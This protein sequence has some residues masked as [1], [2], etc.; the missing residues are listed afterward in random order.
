MEKWKKFENK[1]VQVV[2][3]LNKN[4]KVYGNIYIKGKFSKSSR[5]V[6]V[7]LVDPG[8]Y[9]FMV[10]E[11]KDNAR[12]I[13]TPAIEAFVT[14]LKDLGAEKG[15]V[16]SNSPYT[17]GAQNLAKEFNIDLLHLVDDSDKDIRTIIYAT[18]LIS[19]VM[20]RGFSVG[21]GTT[22]TQGITFQDDVKKLTFIGV[23][24]NNVTAYQIFSTLW[25]ETEELAKSPGSYKYTLPDDRSISILGNDGGS[26]A[27]QKL[28]FNYEVIE[29]YFVGSVKMIDTSGIYNVKEKSYRTKSLKTEI[30][31][32]YE[33]EKTWR[34]I[35]N[36]KDIMK[37]VTFG[38]SMVSMYPEK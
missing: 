4:S 1:T 9:D 7:K 20:P 25:N 36:P 33:V 26:V 6:D 31:T 15:A 28:H 35:K 29:R 19:D 13:D 5:Q 10:F 16:V 34:E 37:T 17:E 22:S 30:I 18:A 12:S 11:C 21:F 38:V 27:V 14:K 24:G 32:P 2:K 23:D 8:E 3:E